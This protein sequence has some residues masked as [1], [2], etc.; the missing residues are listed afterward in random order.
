M[1]A[2]ASVKASAGAAAALLAAI[3]GAST[4]VRLGIPESANA[5]AP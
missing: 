3:D 1:D 5:Q 4:V 2:S